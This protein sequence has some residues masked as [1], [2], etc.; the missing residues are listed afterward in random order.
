MN[1]QLQQIIDSLK[2]SLQN[3][4]DRFA[5]A[6]PEQVEPKEY[7]NGKIRMH[8]GTFPPY[9]VVNVLRVD[10]EK[11]EVWQEG[12]PVAQPLALF[13]EIESN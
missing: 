7:K 6:R 5:P 12:Y 8:K 10:E 11:G 4:A 3:F 1:E 9:K 2:E 13:H